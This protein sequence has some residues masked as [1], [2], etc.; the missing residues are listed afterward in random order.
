MLL[1]AD[2]F[3][4]AG[5]AAP[6]RWAGALLHALHAGRSLGQARLP[7][8]TQGG[9]LRFR[10]PLAEAALAEGTEIALAVEVGGG[11]QPL[12]RR[13]IATRLAGAIDRC[14]ESLVRGWAANLAC[15]DLP[16]TVEIWLDGQMVGSAPAERRRSDLERMGRELGATGFL[17]KFPRPLA[18][19]PG[20]ATEVSVRIQGTGITLA[21][22]P[23]ALSHRFA[24][25]PVLGR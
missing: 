21:N 6:G 1:A 8:A 7:E 15:P 17:F 9:P 12:A 2:R 22:S 20:Q 25:L 5:E 14:N 19:P 18:L 24:E 23:W 3:H 10:I 13:R 16:V 11:L 4:L